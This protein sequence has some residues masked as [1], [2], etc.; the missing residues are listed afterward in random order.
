M[1]KILKKEVVIGICAIIA[2]IILFSGIEF[3][4]GINV[5]KPENR[6]YISYTNVAGLDIAS[7]VTINGFKI[8]Q[9]LDIE[10]EYN[11]PGY[12]LVEIS[13]NKDLKLPLGTKAILSPDL[14][15]AA[16]IALEM[17]SGDGFYSYDDRIEGVN[18]SYLMDNINKDIIPSI[19]AII[20]KVDTLLTSVNRII[21][22]PAISTSVKRLDDIT[23]NLSS[24]TTELNSLMKSLPPVVRNIDGLTSNLN[25]ISEDLAMVSDDLK[26]MPIDSTLNCVNNTSK[27]LETITNDLKKSINSNE[28]TLGLLMKDN[29]LYNNLNGAALNLD[30]LLIDVK[31]N[32]KRYISIKLF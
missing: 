18:P 5:F 8:G 14:L 10:Y 27:N 23:S 2:S 4:K 9:V 7:P 21:G 19:T 13:L 20:P 25:K 26:S 6:Y 22:D 16:S 30:S 24:I 31:K 15:G 1:K 28:S 17:G 3:L 32:P 11:N 12:V 29:S